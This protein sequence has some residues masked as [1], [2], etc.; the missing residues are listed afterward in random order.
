MNKKKGSGSPRSML[1]WS[2]DTVEESTLSPAVTLR[3]GM[4]R[5]EAIVCVCD[6]QSKTETYGDEEERKCVFCGAERWLSFSQGHPLSCDIHGASQS[7]TLHLLPLIRA[8]TSCAAVRHHNSALCAHHGIKNR[9]WDLL[10]CRTELF[11]CI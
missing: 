1:P 11:R 10:N 9:I 2:C 7:D 8:A 6:R 3:K 5:S 4:C